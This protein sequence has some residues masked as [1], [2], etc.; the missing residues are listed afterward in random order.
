MHSNEVALL[1]L[2][3]GLLKF[4]CPAEL[5]TAG[6]IPISSSTAV[7]SH[8]AVTRKTELFNN[9]TRVKHASI[10]ESIRPGGEKG[11]EEELRPAT[12]HKL[13]SAPVLDKA[14]SV[15]GVVQ[16]CHKGFD[17]VSSGPDFTLEDL[18]QLEIA[19]K[20]LSNSSF[21]QPGFRQP[22]S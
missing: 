15:L 20:A 19:A 21:M 14:E 3:S 9:F 4:L 5:A 16:I 17:L 6:S 22:G 7:A 1:R 18:Q 2:E 12:I 13:M 10:F 8:T 11:D